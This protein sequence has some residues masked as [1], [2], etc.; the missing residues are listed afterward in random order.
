[1]WCGVVWCG[2]VWC[3]VVWCDV[4]R[5]DVMWCGVVWC[6]VWRAVVWNSTWQ[7][8]SCR[9]AWN[10]SIQRQETWTS[11]FSFTLISMINVISFRFGCTNPRQ[12]AQKLA[13]VC[14]RNSHIT[15]GN[16]TEISLKLPSNCRAKFSLKRNDL[17]S[18]L[19]KFNFFGKLVL[20]KKIK[21]ILTD[22]LSF[23]FSK[24]LTIS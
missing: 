19:K 8:Y 6:G 17:P 24:Y 22:S 16:L 5:C 20:P 18:S 14:S 21:L 11:L 1:M 9:M 7:I 12:F 10:M 2:V 3:G 23:I 15:Q 4:M 13:A